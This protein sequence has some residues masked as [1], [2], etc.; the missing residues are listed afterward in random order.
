MYRPVC[1]MFG[2]EVFPKAAA[3]GWGWSRVGWDWKGWRETWPE[4][5]TS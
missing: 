1:Q 3:A 5:G 2:P 4:Q